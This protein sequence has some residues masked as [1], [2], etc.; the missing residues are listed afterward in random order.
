MS[1]LRRLS[2]LHVLVLSLLFSYS[3]PVRSQALPSG[4]VQQDIGA[5]GVAGSA[6]YS[7]GVFTISGAG[8][9][10]YG[11]ADGFHFVYQPMAGNGSI[12]ARVVTVTGMRSGTNPTA[13]VQHS[14]LSERQ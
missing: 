2:A 7:N 1:V 4:W 8:P 3:Q 10:I 12:I 9:E 11:T 5:V 6:S 14:E 13:S